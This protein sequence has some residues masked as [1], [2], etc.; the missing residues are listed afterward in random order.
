[1]NS[2]HVKK[3]KEEDDISLDRRWCYC[4]RSVLLPSF[5]FSVIAAK[6]K[7]ATERKKIAIAEQDFS[8][9]LQ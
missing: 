5:P 1:M 9:S 7:T 4:Q 2:I 6:W 8:Q 3:K